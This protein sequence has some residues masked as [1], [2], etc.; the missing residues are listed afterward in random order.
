MPL[1]HHFQRRGRV[2]VAVRV[3]PQLPARLTVEQAAWVLGCQPHD[4]PILIMG[5]LLKLSP[6]YMRSTSTP[7]PLVVFAIA[8][9]NNRFASASHLY[10]H[11]ALE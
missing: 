9:A 7:T 4:A 8:K 5:R 2:A 6:N 10:L 11:A 3:R 1:Y